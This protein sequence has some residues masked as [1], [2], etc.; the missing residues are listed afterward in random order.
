MTA[1]TVPSRRLSAWRTLGGNPP[2]FFTLE[3]AVGVVAAVVGLTQP[4][5]PSIGAPFSTLPSSVGV[6]V[7]IGYWTILALVGSTMVVKMRNGAVLGSFIAFVTAAAVLGGPPAAVVVGFV[8]TLEVRELRDLRPAQIATNHAETLVGAVAASFVAIGA[9]DVLALLPRLGSTF[10]SLIAT[11]MA[12]LAYLLAGSALTYTGIAVR[13]R[14]RFRDVWRESL[15]DQ[16]MFGLVAAAITWVLVEMYLLVAWWSPVVVIVPVLAAWRALDRDR[17]RWEA[18][19]DTLTRL[20]NRGLLNRRLAVA[21]AR[22]RRDGRQSLVLIVDLDGFKAIN[23]EHG[24]TAGDEVLRSVARRLEGQT[25]HGDV[26]A[27]LGGDEFAVLMVDVDDVQL[28]ERAATRIRLDLAVPISIGS[29]EISIGASVGTAIL[30]REMNDAAY[31][32]SLADESLYRDK[33][34]RSRAPDGSRHVGRPPGSST[35]SS[36]A[37]GQGTGP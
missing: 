33:R 37:I 12:T 16:G 26:V 17:A 15:G 4:V 30:S 20:A 13:Q 27:R 3:I 19:H 29:T 24:H 35:S 5:S 21:A 7:G 36:T 18:D 9:S 32:L 10:T 6:I 23:D 14:R 8:G 2:W 11:V 34:Q 31:V 25:R 28:A 1:S 22:A